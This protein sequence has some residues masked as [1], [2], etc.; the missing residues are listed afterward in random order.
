[1]SEVASADPT[2][3]VVLLTPG[4]L[5]PPGVLR[6]SP[7]VISSGKAPTIT[8]TR[9]DD[10]LGLSVL[11]HWLSPAGGMTSKLSELLALEDTQKMPHPNTHEGITENSLS[12]P[13]KNTLCVQIPGN[14]MSLL[15]SASRTRTLKR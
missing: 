14:P 4:T 15:I 6:S 12:E 2:C 10:S 3:N 9:N 8:Q 5:N 7:D 11:I 1:M 13:K